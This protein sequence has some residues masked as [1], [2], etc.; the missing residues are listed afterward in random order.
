MVLAGSLTDYKVVEFVEFVAFVAFAAASA[1]D[2][3]V[4]AL[5]EGRDWRTV[6]HWYTADHMLRH[7]SWQHGL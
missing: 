2:T 6:R 5:E 4:E 3:E 1:G 7:F